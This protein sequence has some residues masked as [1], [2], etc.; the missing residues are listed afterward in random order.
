[1]YKL[2]GAVKNLRKNLIGAKRVTDPS[3]TQINVL[4]YIL[5]VFKALGALFWGWSCDLGTT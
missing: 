1:M 3:T 4:Y 5:G 2:L